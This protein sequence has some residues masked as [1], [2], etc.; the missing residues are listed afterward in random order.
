M[1]S[2]DIKSINTSSFPQQMCSCGSHNFL[3]WR[4]PE[5]FVADSGMIAGRQCRQM[6]PV[7]NVPH[8]MLLG[9]TQLTNNLIN[10]QN[11]NM[12]YNFQL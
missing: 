6:Q 10:I 7:V 8:H 12:D 9:I 4:H 2:A 11:R 5:A 1:C 3:V